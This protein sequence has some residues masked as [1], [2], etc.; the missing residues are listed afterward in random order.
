[1]KLGDGQTTIIAVSASVAIILILVLLLIVLCFARKFKALKTS[2]HSSSFTILGF[3]D[4]R[5]AKPSKTNPMPKPPRT[6]AYDRMSCEDIPGTLS[7][8]S[9]G[10]TYLLADTCDGDTSHVSGEFQTEATLPRRETNWTRQAC[11]TL[12]EVQKSS[13]PLDCPDM[14]PLL[15]NRPGCRASIGTISISSMSTIDPI[16]GTIEH[17][18]PLPYPQHTFKPSHPNSP[19]NHPICHQRPGYVTLPRRPKSSHAQRPS[20]SSLDCLG[21]RTSA[22]GSSHSNIST[23][24]MNKCTDHRCQTTMLPPYS[25]P[26]P[27]SISAINT[28]GLPPQVQHSSPQKQGP[29]RTSTP[30]TVPGPSPSPSRA[31]LDTIPEQD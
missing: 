31:Q 19:P 15:V 27:A 5:S 8:G 22:D 21:P 20:L 24:P 26:P 1:M 28:V 3:S 2:S 7:R 4:T 25:P 23:L 17:P 30:K 13:D 6:G 11:S 10:L 12:F 18:Y 14:F 29:V 9:T 16:Y